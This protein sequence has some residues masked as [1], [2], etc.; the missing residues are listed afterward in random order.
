MPYCQKCG[1]ELSTEA[2]FCPKCGTPVMLEQVT[3]APSEPSLLGEPELKLAFWG[4]RFIAWLIDA[5]VIGIIVG[6]LGL[7]TWFAIGS[8]SW[9]SAW[10]NWVPFF[11]FNSSGIIYFLY[12]FLMDGAYGQSLGKMAMHLR[13]VRLDGNRPTTGQVALET[14]GKA[15][16]L[17]LDII[18]GL[19]LYP[20]SRQRLFNH[21]SETIV[22]RETIT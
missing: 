15:F 8:L 10:P 17:P 5:I 1:N 14:V 6:I 3:A 7:F 11:N 16:L 9:W 13:V 2:K 22:V 4:E 21:L 20:N 12:W 19:I 18:L